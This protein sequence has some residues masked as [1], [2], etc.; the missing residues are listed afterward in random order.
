MHISN[1]K[2]R[3]NI[4]HDAI[5]LCHFPNAVLVMEQKTKNILFH[6]TLG[7]NSIRSRA[8]VHVILYCIL[9]PFF[10]LITYSILFHDI[11]LLLLPSY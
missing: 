3:Y 5:Y 6:S 1:K 7:I 4:I 8:T 11:F 9:Y 2:V 10:I